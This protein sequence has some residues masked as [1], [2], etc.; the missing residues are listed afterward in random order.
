MILIQLR[1]EKHRY[2]ILQNIDISPC[3]KRQQFNKISP[4]FFFFKFRRQTEQ[5][6]SLKRTVPKYNGGHVDR[7]E[8]C[9][10]RN[11]A[12]NYAHLFWQVFPVP[13][14][15]Q[16]RI[17]PH[18][19]LCSFTY[20]TWISWPWLLCMCSCFQILIRFFTEH[21]RVQVRRWKFVS[22]YMNE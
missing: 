21:F 8:E 17:N 13:I 3:I 9:S 18:A 14:N 16:A 12:R 6:L 1:F 5:Y 4:A 10:N 19:K 7:A 22:C 2:R 20:S 15:S 11:H